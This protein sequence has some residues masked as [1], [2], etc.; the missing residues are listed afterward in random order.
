MIRYFR[1]TLSCLLLVA[2]IV[3]PAVSMLPVEANAEST[4]FSDVT[5]PSQFY[6]DP[7]YWAAER[8]ITTGFSDGTFRPLNNCNRASI[9]TFLWR[10][11]GSPQ[12]QKLHNYPF[13]D[14]T[15][16]NDFNTAIMWAAENGIATGFD[17]GTFRPWDSCNRAS[18]VTFLWRYA[19]R[20]GSGKFDWNQF[21][22]M[23][24][25]PD[26]NDAITWAATHGI[27]TGWP[28]GT[29]R[30]WATCNRLS[31]ITFLYRFQ[32]PVHVWDNWT[33]DFFGSDD[34][35][36]QE[37]SVN[38][39]EDRYRRCIYCDAFEACE[40]DSGFVLLDDGFNH[41]MNCGG[42]WCNHS[43]VLHDFSGPEWICTKCNTRCWHNQGTIR[44]GDGYAHC[45][46]CGARACLHENIIYYYEDPE[47]ANVP[48]Q[49]TICGQQ[50]SNRE[51]EDLCHY[52]E[53][54]PQSV[55]HPVWRP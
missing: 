2:L 7:I 6:Y 21:N 4:L 53:N 14:P 42:V 17:D 26:F 48:W 36:N 43:Y 50:F 23:T 9:V 39:S 10:Y 30:P 38:Y 52:Y 11:A 45:V 16:N 35:Y 55:Y 15:S 41:C 46:L 18:M 28:D 19:Q 47:D 12:P 33:W 54:Y 22:D 51:Y 29:F 37:Y 44:P 8:G 27:T 49:C 24:G 1:K 5:D 3:L 40:H 34:A 31:V 32:E 13:S 20:P 25:N